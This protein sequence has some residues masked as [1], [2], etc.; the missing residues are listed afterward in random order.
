MKNKIRLLIFVMIL[1][2][3]Q[4]MTVSAASKEEMLKT[5][6]ES[7]LEE[8]AELF[9]DNITEP[10]CG[11]VGGEWVVF[12][13]ARWG[14]E[15][16]EEWF[17]TYYKNL[18]EYVISCD[19][20]LHA[21]K[22]TE[23]SRVILALTAIGKDPADVGGYN[24]LKP[25]AD[26]EQTIFQGING[27]AFALLALDSGMYEIPQNQAGTTQASREMYVDYILS[28]E[29]ENGGWA[30]TGDQM[31]IDITAMVLQALAKYRAREDVIEAVE[32]ALQVLSEQQNENGGYTAYEAESSE[33]VSQVITALTE[34]GISVFDERFVKNDKNLVERLLEFRAEDGGFRH[35]MEGDTDLMASE[36]A[37][38]ALAGLCRT[39]NHE[40]S[41]YGAVNQ[42]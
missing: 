23:Y 36:Q 1:C 32:R 35:I 40:T 2:I 25:L 5:V 28:Q 17:E 21:K 31:D 7:T 18:K 33:T 37:F 20:V 16:P 12:G 3:C 15:V 9:L 27:P 42:E 14:G 8:C 10:V 38:Y 19:G 41:L 4:W 29:L 24:L 13:L 34:L 26:F 22:Y 11:S 6:V 39:L 30:L